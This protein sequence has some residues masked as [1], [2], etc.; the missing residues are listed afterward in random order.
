MGRPAILAAV[1]T[2]PSAGAN[3]TV[4][5]GEPGA[6]QLVNAVIRGDGSKTEWS[7]PHGLETVLPGVAVLKE[8]SGGGLEP[9]STLVKETVVVDENEVKVVFATA[10][11][12]GAVYWVQVDG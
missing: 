1:A 8:A 9:A 6:S 10:P 3:G 5:M 4:T 11:A 7:I 12:S 2:R